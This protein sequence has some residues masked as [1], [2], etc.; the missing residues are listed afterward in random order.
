MKI[1]IL[2]FITILSFG[3]ELPKEFSA[4]FNQTIISNNKKLIY[5]GKIFYNK[6]NIVW[7][8][9]YP[10]E[11]IIWILDKIYIYEP[12]LYQVTITKRDKTTLNEIIKNAK[13]IKNNLYESTIKDKKIYFIYDRTLKKLYYTD[14]VGNKVKINFYNQKKSVNKKAFDLKLPEDVDFIYR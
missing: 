13:K 11:K 5:K 7:K 6:G 4:D 14:D 3:I 1:I 8:Y 10:T 9:T 12:D 2:F